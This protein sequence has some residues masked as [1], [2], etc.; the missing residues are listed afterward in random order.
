MRSQVLFGLILVTLAGCWVAGGQGLIV[1][2]PV[3]PI[4]VSSGGVSTN[5]LMAY[6]RLD[7]TS[8]NRTNNFGTILPLVDTGSVGSDTGL[9]TNAVLSGTSKY[10]SVNGFPT[11]TGPDVTWAITLWI[12][13]T[14]SL[15][16]Q[17]MITDRGSGGSLTAFALDRLANNKIEFFIGDCAGGNVTIMTNSATVSANQWSLIYAAFNATNDTMYLSVNGAAPE[18]TV[19]SFGG[20]ICDSGTWYLGA[21]WN[22][23]PG[24]GLNWVGRID[25]M[26]VWNR[27]LTTN[28]LADIFNSNAGKT[29]CDPG[30]YVP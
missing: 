16:A 2:Q 9:Y 18:T 19:K 24:A 14:D 8:G 26:G 21:W 25:E 28:E 6:Y 15:V 4:S 10:L 29:C 7:E 23:L 1:G 27:T 20:N 17:H 13:P 12:Y 5:G 11:P 30:F 3:K 22:S